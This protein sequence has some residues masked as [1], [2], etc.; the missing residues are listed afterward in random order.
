MVVA[1]IYLHPIQTLQALRIRF[2]WLAI[3]AIFK[4]GA[5]IAGKG[6]LGI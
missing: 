2:R 3:I 1:G 5:Q 6:A 4:A